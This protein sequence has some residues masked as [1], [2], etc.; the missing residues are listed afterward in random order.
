MNVRKSLAPAG[1]VLAVVFAVFGGSGAAAV[2]PPSPQEA[3]T[4]VYKFTPGTPLSYKTTGAQVQ[5]VDVMGQTMTTE[6]QSSL[7]ITL[8]PKGLKDGNHLLGL[9][10]DGMSVNVQGP[11]GGTTPDLKDVIGKSFDFVLSPRGEEV[12]VSGAAS[13]FI[14]M[15]QSG[16]REMTSDFQGIFPNVPAT[17]V[18]VGDK[19]PVQETITQKSDAGEIKIA[20]NNESTLDGFE[21]VDGLDCARIK[22]AVKGVLSGALNQMGMALGMD[23]KL[24]G[25]DT[26]Y[27]AVKEGMFVKSESAVDL[28]GTISAE[29]MGMTIT[30]TGTQRGTSALVKK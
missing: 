22:T 14:D 8:V 23:A 15:G 25:T 11:Q 5:N 4:L 29:G 27:F 7:D 30:F 12:D 20:F 19:W 17:P 16:R 18:K 24:G 2:N 3:V 9:T 1:L 10:I 6:V 21:T 28:A 26:S 13:L